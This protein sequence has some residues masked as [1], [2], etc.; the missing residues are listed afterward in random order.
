MALL[1]RLDDFVRGVSA[2]PAIAVRELDTTR[3]DRNRHHS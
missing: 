2:D 3:G 1:D